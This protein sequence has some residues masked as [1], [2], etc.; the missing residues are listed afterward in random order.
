MSPSHRCVVTILVLA[1][2]NSILC[3]SAALSFSS[4]THNGD[5]GFLKFEIS[6]VY[7]GNLTHTIEI[8]NNVSARVKGGKLFVPLVINATARHY[9]IL[10]D[11]YAS[12]RVQSEILKDDFGNIYAFWDGIEIGREQTFSVRIGYHVLSFNTHYLIN[13]SLVAS[14]DR[15]SYLYMKHTKPEKLIESDREE[16]VSTAENIVGNETNPHKKASKIYNF[17]TRHVRY[18]TQDEEMGALWALNNGVGDC[19]EYSYL[20]V[21]LCRA[22]GIPA[23]IQAGFAFHSFSETTED[24]HMWA[25]YYLEDYGWIPVDSTWRLFDTLDDRHFSSIQS[26]PEVIPYAN[27][28]FNCTSGQAEDEQRV[29]ITPCSIS[30]FEDYSFAENLVKTVSKMKRVKSAIFLGKVFGTSLVFPSEVENVEKEF[31]ECEVY[32]QNA[33]ELW[34]RQPQFAHSSVTSAVD[35]AESALEN[36]WILIAKVFAILLSVPIAIL[37]VALVLLKRCQVK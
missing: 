34:N 15:S 31:L 5:S 27:Y 7:V 36:A 13:S 19:S 37:L 20:F 28:I 29:S 18:V 21:A 30:V 16:I 4:M 35:S 24:G 10:Y 2:I 6:D 17:V 1:S 14:Y 23:R 8:T 25:E 33:V 32:L 3:S 22:A 26:T 9:V 11:V 12:D